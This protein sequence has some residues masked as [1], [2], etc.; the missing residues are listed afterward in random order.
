[1][2]PHEH[3]VGLALLL[4]ALAILTVLL[5]RGLLALLVGVQG[6]FVSGA[7]AVVGFAQGHAAMGVEPIMGVEPLARVSEAHGFALLVLVVAA[8]EFSVGLAMGVAFMRK[9]GSVNVEGASVLRW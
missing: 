9:R 5:R 4:F 6:I 1:M 2:I 3:V 8:A 7:L